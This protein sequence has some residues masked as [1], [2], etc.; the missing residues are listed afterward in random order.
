MT[1]ADGA[2]YRK[3]WWESLKTLG[4]VAGI[5]VV[6]VF[7]FGQCQQTPELTPRYSDVGGLP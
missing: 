2:P 1:W 5:V 3:T 4:K 6:A 7:V